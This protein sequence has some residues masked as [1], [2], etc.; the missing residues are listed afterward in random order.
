MV[1]LGAVMFSMKAVM[2]KL[3]Y[4]HEVIESSSMLVVRMIFS[5][6]FYL[7][8]LLVNRN[9]ESSKIKRNDIYMVIVL[10]T[11]GYYL[12]SIFDF[13]GLIIHFNEN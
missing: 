2:V 9:K 3:I 4:Q 13:E 7:V 6:P 11:L 10:G 12:A 5:L 8:I 1:L